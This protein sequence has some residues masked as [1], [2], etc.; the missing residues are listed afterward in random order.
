L[1]KVPRVSLK[2]HPPSFSAPTAPCRW[3]DRVTPPQ[4]GLILACFPRPGR[5]LPAGARR[6][7]L[8]PT[9][10]CTGI[11][12]EGGRP[13]RGARMSSRRPERAP[14]GPAVTSSSPSLLAASSSTA[15]ATPGSNAKPRRGQ[16]CSSAR[17]VRR[18]AGQ[19]T[20]QERK[21]GLRGERDP[22]VDAASVDLLLA[23]QRADASRCAHHHSLPISCW[24][25]TASRLQR[26]WQPPQAPSPLTSI[27]PHCHR[28]QDAL[29][30]LHQLQA[31]LPAS[32]LERS[33]LPGPQRTFA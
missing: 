9:R 26:S 11:R 1:Q 14:R 5:C 20:A 30:S 28:H 22:A 4:A 2:S 16:Q 21:A 3:P 15:A 13:R 29:C 24:L 31:A 7:P 18:G 23:E 25:A 8:C 27:S 6:R 17:G 12:H 33:R 32:A 19:I 10:I